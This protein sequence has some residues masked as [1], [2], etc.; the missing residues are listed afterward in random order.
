MADQPD[1]V[2]KELLHGIHHQQ[3]HPCQR[4]GSDA[5]LLWSVPTA[6]NGMLF[7]A[8]QKKLWAVATPD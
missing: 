5:S 3:L 4:L 7:V 8:S 6:A 2:G 1:Q